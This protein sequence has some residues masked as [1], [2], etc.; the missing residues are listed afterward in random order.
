MNGRG[1]D[2]NPPTADFAALSAPEAHFGYR[3][4]LILLGPNPTLIQIKT[5]LR[6]S[7]A[8][9]RFSL[10]GTPGRIRTCGLRIRSQKPPVS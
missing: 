5:G 6:R 4:S 9:P 2:S 7:C 10:L 1:Q 8:L 3:L